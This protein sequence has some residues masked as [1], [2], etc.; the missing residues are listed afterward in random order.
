MGTLLD[1]LSSHGLPELLD[2]GDVALDVTAAESS[3]PQAADNNSHRAVTE[4]EIN[5]RARVIAKVRRQQFVLNHCNWQPSGRYGSLK[6]DLWILIQS[7]RSRVRNENWDFSHLRSTRPVAEEDEAKWPGRIGTAERSSQ[8][9]DAK[10]SG[11]PLRSQGP[12]EPG[13]NWRICCDWVSGCPTLRS[14]CRNNCQQKSA[15]TPSI[16]VHR[17]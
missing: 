3:E 2:S 9:H 15:V 10:L 5:Y 17:P 14:H 7:D 16:E 11:R 1:S 4:A 13:T 8:R 6:E 12:M